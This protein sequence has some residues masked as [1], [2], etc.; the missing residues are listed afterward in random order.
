MTTLD[1]N[2]GRADAAMAVGLLLLGTLLFLSGAG[3]AGQWQASLAG[4][5]ALTIEQLLGTAAA[6]SGAV[7]VLWWCV[8]FSC[9]AG[10]LVL[11]RIGKAGAARATRKVSPAFMQRL[12]LAAVSF[13]LLSGAAAHAAVPVPGPAWGPTQGQEA[14]VPA[15]PE[16]AQPV[17]SDGGLSAPATPDPTVSVQPGSASQTPGAGASGYAEMAAAGPDPAS[18][19]SPSGQD[20]VPVPEAGS[21]SPSA[22]PSSFNPGWQPSAPVVDP[23]LLAAP[24]AR[25][26]LQAQQPVGE[27]NGGVAV[28][29]GD[30]LWD[31]VSGYLGPGASDVDIALEWPRWY[32]ANKSVIGPDP[33]T[34]LPG[35]VLLPPAT[36]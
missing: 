7:L 4:N 32:E 33:D 5:R 30:S 20:G 21:Y 31:I 16:G 26:A 23:G 6:V 2:R 24:A 9:A 3:L 28:L 15:I 25:D 18:A 29:S 14:T 36:A 27:G 11:E 10:A 17:R 19:A 13:Q 22:P 1:A 8:A 12:V 35:Q 34:L